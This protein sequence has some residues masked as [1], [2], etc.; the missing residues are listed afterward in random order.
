M[1]EKEWL[2]ISFNKANNP[3]RKNITADDSKRRNN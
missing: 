3:G 2:Q 1:I